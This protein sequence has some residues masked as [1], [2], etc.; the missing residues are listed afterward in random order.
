MKKEEGEEDEAT[1]G[2]EAGEA[3]HE[4]EDE[5]VEEGHQRCP[6]ES[7]QYGEG[8]K[9]LCALCRDS[10]LRTTRATG[11]VAG[12]H[13]LVDEGLAQLEAISLTHAV[14]LQ[15]LSRHGPQILDAEGIVGQSLLLVAI[16]VATH[17]GRSGACLTRAIPLREASRRP[18][19]LQHRSLMVTLL[20]QRRRL[21]ARLPR[22]VLRTTFEKRLRSPLASLV[23][24][25]CFP[26]KGSIFR[27]IF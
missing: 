27:R 8:L 16:S 20:Y 10:R 24:Y 23:R 2:E 6:V 21:S 15:F 11:V 22:L 14:V 17:S 1:D 25:R 26:L 19:S 3:G 12:L 9:R 5:S 7:V 13:L 4:E 18:R